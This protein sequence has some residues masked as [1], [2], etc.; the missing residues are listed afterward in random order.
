[1]A[2]AASVAV[3]VDLLVLL[4]ALEAMALCAYALVWSARTAARDG[5]CGQ[6]LRA[7]RCCDRPFVLGLAILF[8]LYG[9]STS[10]VWIRGVMGTEAGPP[11]TTAFVLI[12]VALAYKLGAFP[13]HSWAL[14]AFESLPRTF[15]A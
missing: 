10:Y 4:I 12:G 6:V 3:A 13:F 2:A 11:V 5:G 15:A 7:R 8:G 14:D 9:G 1:V